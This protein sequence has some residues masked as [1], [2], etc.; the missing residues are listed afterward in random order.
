MNL[1]VVLSFN[2]RYD[3]SED[4]DQQWATAKSGQ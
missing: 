4:G 3:N 2:I 1:Q